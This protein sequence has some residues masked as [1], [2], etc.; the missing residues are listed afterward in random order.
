MGFLTIGII[1]INNANLIYLFL[2][3]NFFYLLKVVSCDLVE[4]DM[5]IRGT[6]EA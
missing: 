5:V 1:L 2:F 3:F 6:W 4:Y